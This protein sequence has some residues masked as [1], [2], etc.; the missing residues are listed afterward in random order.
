MTD[1]KLSNPVHRST[2]ALV[3]IFSI[4]ASS[5]ALPREAN[6]SKSCSF[7]RPCNVNE[8]TRLATS[9]VTR[10]LR[11][12]AKGLLEPRPSGLSFRYLIVS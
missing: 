6:S 3:A 9:L 4:I 12:M 2:A 5:G 8:R 11:P 1:L 10:A 7:H